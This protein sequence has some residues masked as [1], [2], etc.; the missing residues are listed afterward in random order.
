[1]TFTTLVAAAPVHELI[2]TLWNVN[3]SIASANPLTSLELIDTLWNV[4]FVV[5]HVF[6][7]LVSELID[8]LWNVNRISIAFTSALSLAN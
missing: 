8:T 5:G 4:N 2:D 3:D 1:M 7:N 6:Y